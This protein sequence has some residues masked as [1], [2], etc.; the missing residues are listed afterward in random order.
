MISRS[1]NFSA[2]I[3]DNVVVTAV[4]GWGNPP[5]CFISLVAALQFST[6]WHC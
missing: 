2:V 4:T 5:H 3:I 1:L 6:T